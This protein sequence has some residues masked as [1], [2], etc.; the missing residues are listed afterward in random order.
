MK[1]HSNPEKYILFDSNVVASYYLPQSSRSK[2]VAERAKLIIDYVMRGGAPDWLLLIP[3]IAI[4]EVFNVFA[5]YCYGTW[6]PHVQKNLPGGLDQRTYKKIRNNFKKHI[7]N[8]HLF[9]QVELNRYHILYSD[10]ISS[11]DHYYQIY[12]MKGSKSKRITPLQTMDVLI[13]SMGIELNHLLGHERFFIL[14][15]DN[16][17]HDLCR[18]LKGGISDGTVEKLGLKEIASELNLEFSTELYPRILN[19]ANAKISE[20]KA[21]FG[22]WPLIVP[23]RKR[24]QF[25]STA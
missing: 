5:K 12:K 10:L 6:N 13:L 17:M 19:L 15:A 9:H 2:K 22:E 23:K 14:T 16:R 4:A 11:L 3:N 1:R 18:R 25:N 24:R 20:L 7:H 8:R 21:F